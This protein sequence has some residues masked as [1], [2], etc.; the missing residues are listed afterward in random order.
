MEL[1]FDYF[2]DSSV[3]GAEEFPTKYIDPLPLIAAKKK[4]AIKQGTI[5]AINKKPLS[6]TANAKKKR[7][8][9]RKQAN[10][11]D[12]DDDEK[13]H[14]ESDYDPAAIDSDTPLSQ[15]KQSSQQRKSKLSTKR[16]A[17]ASDNRDHE[18]AKSRKRAR[19]P[20]AGVTETASDSSS[21]RPRG[22][23]TRSKTAADVKD[24]GAES[25]K[26]SKRARLDDAV[27]DEAPRP[28][29]RR[30]T[31]KG[32]IDAKSTHSL[33]IV[34]KDS[35]SK[36]ES[37][38]SKGLVSANIGSKVRDEDTSSSQPATTKSMV[39]TRIQSFSA[40]PSGSSIGGK[41]AGIL[42]SS[43]SEEHVMVD[44]GTPASKKESKDTV[45]TGGD[46]DASNQHS[47]MM[48]QSGNPGADTH[49][50]A[51]GGKDAEILASSHS[52][53][54]VMVGE[55]TP[56]CSK[57]SKDDSICS[58]S[59]KQSVMINPVCELPLPDMQLAPTSA[60]HN[61]PNDKAPTAGVATYVCERA[62]CGQSHL[63]ECLTSCRTCKKK[64]CPPNPIATC[65]SAWSGQYMTWSFPLH[66]GITHEDRGMLIDLCGANFATCSAECYVRLIEY[67]FEFKKAH[68]PV[69]LMKEF[70]KILKHQYGA[71]NPD[72]AFALAKPYSVDQPATTMASTLSQRPITSIDATQ[73]LM[74]TDSQ[75]TI[76][77]GHTPAFDSQRPSQDGLSLDVGNNNVVA[78]SQ[79]TL[80]AG[81]YQ[82][83]SQDGLSLDNSDLS[84]NNDTGKASR[85]ENVISLQSEVKAVA[86]GS[87]QSKVVDLSE[88]NSQDFPL[89]NQVLGKLVD[90]KSQDSAV[91]SQVA[92]PV[93]IY[94]EAE[95]N[96]MS[97]HEKAGYKAMLA[98]LPVSP[99]VDKAYLYAFDPHSK[100]SWC[101][102]VSFNEE[103]SKIMKH[104]VATMVDR[105]KEQL[106]LSDRVIGYCGYDSKWDEILPMITKP[107]P[108]PDQLI[109]LTASW[110]SGLKLTP[111][112]AIMD[113]FF[114]NLRKSSMTK[115]LDK[116]HNNEAKGKCEGLQ[117]MFLV[118][119]LFASATGLVQNRQ[120]ARSQSA[121][122]HWGLL[123]IDTSL[124]N[125]ALLFDSL[126][127]ADKFTSL[128]TDTPLWNAVKASFKC[129]NKTDITV[130]VVP[131]DEQEDDTSCGLHAMW[132][133]IFA[134]YH[135]H[136]M[137]VNHNPHG[138]EKYHTKVAYCMQQ[139]YQVSL[140]N[141]LTLPLSFQIEHGL[142]LTHWLKR[143]Q[144]EFENDKTRN[145]SFVVDIAKVRQ[146]H[147]DMPTD[148]SIVL[149]EELSEMDHKHDSGPLSMS[150][151]GGPHLGQG[152]S[153]A[154]IAV[155]VAD[156]KK[157]SAP[158]SRPPTS[159]L[160]AKGGLVP[161]DIDENPV[162][163][164]P[165]SAEKKND[166]TSSGGVP[167]HSAATSVD[168]SGASKQET[169]STPGTQQAGKMRLRRSDITPAAG[170]SVTDV[171]K[172]TKGSSGNDSEKCI[173][174]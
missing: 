167:K 34:G 150:T 116:L 97:P 111:Y 170:P 60:Q 68:D 132:Y 110:L 147:F 21:L 146:L 39:Q 126:H 112:V 120:R 87:S 78:I 17:D 163:R 114:M 40:K 154:P 124:E 107:L 143:L 101:T 139:L 63:V 169:S 166:D 85:V 92:H 161:M 58:A 25:T 1:F 171:K 157:K 46:S 52:E 48:D 56:S 104:I 140:Q 79:S 123:V 54:H 164:P 9:R 77:A 44:D 133:M 35:S 88:N 28:K 69:L 136:T 138:S 10:A 30:S 18:K 113:S 174:I 145:K 24:T 106:N 75:S 90:G 37:R 8:K 23:R 29:G 31:S 109:N 50:S 122:G 129:F 53:E 103:F 159:A 96:L 127:E 66:T 14:D 80:P 82:S 117:P 26:S 130:T 172:V 137:L 20:F 70:L 148:R 7:A 125:N 151:P 47:V 38:H 160:E 165:E 42:A 135:L 142:C 119:P 99:T 94:T 89:F 155:T 141:G 95:L 144:T 51:I 27:D 73:V 67:F 2:R 118:I 5:T 16:D 65:R 74:D 152:E 149:R 57:E 32:T 11:K 6:D 98:S 41:D 158:S 93:R 12:G 84:V 43:H 86:G 81:P 55:G 19:V 49:S 105:D 121:P 36:G 45:I 173:V 59:K 72:L 156:N 91:M 168:Q 102:S 15:I 115:A 62:Q 131:V 100:P 64:L 3:D 153:G 162:S 108:L 134:V 22:K 128:L 83:L 33:S 61:P 71:S 13:S 4:Q 76:A